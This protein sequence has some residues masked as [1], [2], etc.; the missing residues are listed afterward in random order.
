MGV[1]HSCRSMAYTIGIWR[2][3]VALRRHLILSS[4]GNQLPTHWHIEEVLNN[5]QPYANMG[6][7]TLKAI[8]FLF[9]RIGIT[10]V[11]NLWDHANNTWKSYTKKLEHTRGVP[12][13]L[14]ELVEAILEDLQDPLWRLPVSGSLKPTTLQQMTLFKWTT[15]KH[16]GPSW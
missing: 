4:I 6:K 11:D 5:L 1:V 3:W 9:G 2:A 16:I 15:G 13:E 12:Q 8:V 10:Q 7:V 14:K